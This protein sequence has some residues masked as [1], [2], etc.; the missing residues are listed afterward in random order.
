MKRTAVVVLSLALCGSI[1]TG[2]SNAQNTYEPEKTYSSAVSIADSYGI[3]VEEKIKDM[4]EIINAAYPGS[5]YMAG[6]ESQW[7]ELE[8]RAG[9]S[10]HYITYEIGEVLNDDKDG[11]SHSFTETYDYISYRSVEEAEPGDTVLTY[12]VWCNSCNECDD[13]IERYDVVLE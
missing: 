3:A 10:Y 6:G 12:F 11:K 5:Y 1:A 7:N 4:E 9:K 8:A 2:C 13:M